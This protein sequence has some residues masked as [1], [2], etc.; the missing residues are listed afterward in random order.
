MKI[1]MTGRRTTVEQTLRDYLDDRL[2]RLEKHD[3][4]VERVEVEVCEEANPRLA[5][6]KVR[7][8]LTW[9]GRGP[10]V[11]SEAAAADAHAAVD[12]ALGRLDSRLR[13]VADRRRIHHG[14]RTP[15]SVAVATAAVG[16][17]S[18]DDATAG[19]VPEPAVADDAGDTG[20]MVVREKEHEAS[21]MT[22]DQALFEMELVG[23]EFFL[24]VDAG[25]GLP[26]VVY[27]RRGYD[28]GVLRL[29]T[30]DPEPP[31]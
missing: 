15:V 11:R 4:R 14:A 20:P 16:V 1:V 29:R 31:S 13:K 28:Y 6:Q 12:L 5:G 19:V 25:S 24:F 23:H 18:L 9:H 17:A 7:V 2:T 22:L 30:T 21:P 26:S 3:P 10:I 27:R 8:E